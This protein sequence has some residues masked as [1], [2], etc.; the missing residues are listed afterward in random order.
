MLA[1][2]PFAVVML[3][4]GQDMI[5]TKAKSTALLDADVAAPVHASLRIL[6]TAAVSNSSSGD[7]GSGDSGSTPTYWALSGNANLEMY[8]WQWALVGVLTF[9]CCCCM[10]ACCI[11][12]AYQYQQRNK[13]GGQRGGFQTSAQ[14]ASYPGAGGG[15]EQ[16]GAY[17]GTGTMVGG[18]P[19]QGSF[20]A[21]GQ[22]G[23]TTPGTYTAAY[24][25]MNTGYGP[26]YY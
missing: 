21:Y 16:Y 22:M 20:N 9:C 12:A 2:V 13:M 1:L 17:S 11:G 25:G 19:V 3:A 15:Y 18:V 5:D 14:L 10:C 4:N 26:S 23:M 7:S 8:T 24:P 6:Q